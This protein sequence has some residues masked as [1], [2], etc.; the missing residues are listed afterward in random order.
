MQQLSSE[1][2]CYSHLHLSAPHALQNKP[3]E[4][5]Q[6]EYKEKKDVVLAVLCNS[7]SLTI[8]NIKSNLESAKGY[9]RTG[10][11]QLL[12]WLDSAV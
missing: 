12:S 4:E 2:L 11:A 6:E 7:T 9:E 8:N 1:K 5:H 3:D 10:A